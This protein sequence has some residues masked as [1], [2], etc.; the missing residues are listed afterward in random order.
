MW[1]GPMLLSA[2]GLIF[3]LFPNWVG[4]T[5]VEPA[6]IA[7]HATREE[8]QLKLFYGF[9]EP[10]LLS[11]ATL[12]LGALIYAGRR[13]LRQSIGK[14]LD[15]LPVTAAGI[16]D[17]LLLTV[18]ILAKR[19]TRLLQ[20]GSLFRYLT[21][22]ISAIMVSVGL[23]L[24]TTYNIELQWRTT[25]VQ[26]WQG[27]LMTLIIAAVIVAARSTSRLLAICALGIVGAGIAIVFLSF[28]APDVALTQLLVETL[29]LVIASIVLLRLPPIIPVTPISILKRSVRLMVAIGSGALVA[30][31]LIAV[32]QFEVDR[33]LTQF[34]EQASYLKAHGRNIVN[35]I[36]VDFRSLD[37]LGEIIVVAASA[38][39]SLALIRKRRTT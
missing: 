17:K 13:P 39:A 2:V 18:V 19:Q 5:L 3:G 33:T 4:R 32:S 15:W 38:L 20:N 27:I 28:G 12:T 1:L 8:I 25:H 34:Y 14:W 29:T 36:L 31:M 11:V 35:V 22:I 24:V 16:Y 21:V 10:L 37:T 7:F 30:A 26:M 23:I 9:N 6:V